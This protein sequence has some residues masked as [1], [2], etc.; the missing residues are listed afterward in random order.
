M[1]FSLFPAVTRAALGFVFVGGVVAVGVPSIADDEIDVPIGFDVSDPDSALTMSFDPAT[2]GEWAPF[3]GQTGDPGS[4]IGG[5]V[6]RIVV[7]DAR[8]TPDGWS[9]SLRFVEPFRLDGSGLGVPMGALTTIGYPRDPETLSVAGISFVTVTAG[10]SAA[11][12]LVRPISTA[13]AAVPAG[14]YALDAWLAVVVPDDA[15]AGHYSTVVSIDL[16]GG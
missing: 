5:F 12:S 7:D 1:P 3:D 16:V 10:T 6:G 8:S 15:P 2:A 11:D 9:L 4:T 14:S 13:S